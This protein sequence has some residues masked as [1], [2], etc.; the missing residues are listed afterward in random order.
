MTCVQ[1]SCA[2]WA[3]KSQCNCGID[4][5]ELVQRTMESRKHNA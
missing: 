5:I 4:W 3:Q 1:Q 2:W